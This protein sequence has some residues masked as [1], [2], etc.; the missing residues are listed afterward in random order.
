MPLGWLMAIADPQNNPFSTPSGKIEIYSQ[1]LAYLAIPDLPP[2]PKYMEADETRDSPLAPKYPLQL[3]TTHFRKRALSQFDNI[4]WLK[5]LGGQELW[6]LY[7]FAIV[8]GTGEGGFYSLSTAMVGDIFGLRN[9]GVIM[10]V[11]AAAWGFG[12]AIGPAMG[13]FIFDVSRSYQVAFVIGALAVILV[14][15]LVAGLR[16]EVASA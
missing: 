7:I 2:I 6:S 14:T 3:I 10:G 16:Q 9:I 8:F 4:P 12:A 15:F 5:E 13:G 1:R 11:L